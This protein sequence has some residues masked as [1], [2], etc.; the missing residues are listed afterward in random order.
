MTTQTEQFKAPRTTSTAV[1]LTIAVCLAAA[2]IAITA[3]SHSTGG[4]LPPATAPNVAPAPKHLQKMMEA[5]L[6]NKG[7]PSLIYQ[8]ALKPADQENFRHHFQAIA[9]SR[10]WY[11]HTPYP[12]GLSV[13]LPAEELPELQAA[14]KDPAGWIKSNMATDLTPQDPSSLNLVNVQMHTNPTKRTVRSTLLF[15]ATALCWITALYILIQCVRRAAGPH[16]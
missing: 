4:D 7:R 13:V 9:P 11:P 1:L 8:A 15:A 5:S 6:R 14:T 2:G 16:R 12:G 3:F 10:G